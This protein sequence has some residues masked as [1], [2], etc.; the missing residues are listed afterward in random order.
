MPDTASSAKL[1][2]ED[3]LRRGRSL[4]RLRLAVRSLGRLAPG[5]RHA[6]MKDRLGDYLEEVAFRSTSSSTSSLIFPRHR[7]LRPRAQC[8]VFAAAPMHVE[9]FS[10]TRSRSGSSSP[11]SK[12]TEFPLCARGRASSLRPLPTLT[13]P[14]FTESS[15]VGAA[16]NLG[17]C[18]LF[19]RPRP[20]RLRSSP[21]S[22]SATSFARQT[23]PTRVSRLPLVAV[24]ATTCSDA[25][26]AAPTD[27]TQPVA[28]LGATTA[29]PVPPG[30]RPPVARTDGG[31]G[32][33]ADRASAPGAS[34]V[35]RLRPRWRAGDP[36]RRL[37]PARCHNP[38]RSL[39]LTGPRQTST[40]VACASGRSP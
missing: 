35:P 29:A 34:R 10:S 14:A 19:A 30:G 26:V 27:T 33:R 15:N 17:F 5:A 23:S 21:S 3:L 22:P 25:D 6:S 39:N 9:A 37:T 32:A 7:G 8:S 11:V 38:L 24:P 20:R 31:A 12:R 36:P 18:P 13:R 16:L 2:H 4:P 1:S 40:A 28:S